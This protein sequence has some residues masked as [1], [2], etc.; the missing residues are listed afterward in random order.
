VNLFLTSGM[1]SGR[2]SYFADGKTYLASF[3][4]ADFAELGVVSVV[5]EAV[6]FAVADR[7]HRRILNLMAAMF[8]PLLIFVY[9][10]ARSF[11]G[12]IGLLMESILR[13]KGGDFTIDLESQP[14]DELGA[15]AGSLAEMAGALGERERIAETFGKPVGR[16]I[17]ERAIKNELA[18]GGERRIATLL[19]TE[20][21][22]FVDLADD[23]EP[24]EAVEYLN[25]YLTAVVGCVET[26]G[27]LVDKLHGDGAT[28]LWGIPAS[29]GR[30]SE[31][32]VDAALLM[33]AA[34]R[35]LNQARAAQRKPRIAMG[36]AVDS[37][38]VLAGRVGSGKRSEY[39]ALGAMVKQVARLEAL[40]KRFEVDILVSES[41]RV[42]LG[43]IYR[44]AMM[45][46]VRVTEKNRPQHVYAVLGR[47]DDVN[48]PRS[49][50]ELRS[51]LGGETRG[52]DVKIPPE[53][54]GK[55]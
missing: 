18:L 34:L 35:S 45:P 7:I 6:V 4:K 19:Y 21:R 14:R 43:S 46:R 25:E 20:A 42:E 16:E 28:A 13:V 5:P 2:T 39:M 24:K 27:G 9:L 47:M 36:C 55:K 51:R 26:T 1:D 10:Y 29:S 37:G 11:S 12:R 38:R 3:I 41:V 8:V 23:L 52:V 15:L 32:A 22:G 17:A 40:A 44:L 48:A 49:I 54:A 33:R 50:A 30:D 31:A 53:N